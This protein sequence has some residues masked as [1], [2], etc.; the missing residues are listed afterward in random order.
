M[1]SPK[2][3]LELS[4]ASLTP[5]ALS[6]ATIVVIDA[7]N[8]YVDGML[9]LPGVAPALAE[10]AKLL[11]RARAAKTPIV[12]IAH[13]GKPGGGVFDP[14]GRSGQIADAVAPAEGETVIGKAL[15]NAF[16]GTELHETL[17]TIGRKE[18]ILAGFM[19]HMC[20]SST[21]R[22]ALDLGYRCTVVDAATA[23]RDLPDGRG[24]VIAADALHRASL[25]ALADRFAIVTLDVA[26]LPD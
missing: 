7:Q 19:T 3:L 12:H 9:A 21:A 6:D 17:E 13:H 5:S 24:G 1:A 14:D 10:G 8:E 26:A 18:L 23:T 22:A 15:P 2:T 20:I 16:A 25:A 11:A 4:G